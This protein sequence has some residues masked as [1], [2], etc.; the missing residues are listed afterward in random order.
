[1]RALVVEALPAA[2]TDR[3]LAVA[4]QILLAAVEEHVVLARDVE[5]ALDTR[6]LEDLGDRVERARLL[7][8]R[9]VAGVK[10]ER[11]HGAQ[12]IHPVDHLLQGGGGVLVGLAL[13]AHVRVADLHEPEAALGG[14]RAALGRI[15]GRGLGDQA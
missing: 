10:Q 6:A 4:A 3:A 14:V 11:G 5:R 13:E 7:A 9:L 1:M 12:R 2:A 8:V 15:R